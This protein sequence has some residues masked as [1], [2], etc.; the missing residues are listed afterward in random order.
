MTLLVVRIQVVKLSL[1]IE[2]TVQPTQACAHEYYEMLTCYVNQTLRLL[3]LNSTGSISSPDFCFE[4]EPLV[5]G[6]IDYGGRIEPFALG[7]VAT[8]ACNEGFDLDL[9][10]GGSE[11]RTC[12][13][14]NGLDAIG[15]FD[16]QAP[17]CIRK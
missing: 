14:G 2:F 3:I 1:D 13:D 5:N 6:E 4:L 10:L 7:T 12:V 15:V 9:S 11:M 17:R 8:Y 16:N